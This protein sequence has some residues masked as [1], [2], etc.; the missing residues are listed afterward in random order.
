MRIES[1]PSKRSPL[2]V[3][4]VRATATLTTH[5][6]KSP[7]AA[8]SPKQRKRAKAKALRRALKRVDVREFQVSESRRMLRERYSWQ[9]TA[10]VTATHVLFRGGGEFTGP[11]VKFAVRT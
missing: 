7:D 10:G 11:T 1:T 4:W 5:T 8:G 6:G 3:A 9:V 2:F